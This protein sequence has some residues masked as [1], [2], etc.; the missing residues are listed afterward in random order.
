M[1][2]FEKL[3]A[4][5]TYKQIPKTDLAQ[6]V[7]YVSLDHLLQWQ[8]NYRAVGFAPTATATKGPRTGVAMQKIYNAQVKS[9]RFIIKYI[10]EHNNNHDIYI[11]YAM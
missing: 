10:H 8:R 6:L 3:H 9:L 4:G 7:Q 11:W 2:D 5:Q 1:P